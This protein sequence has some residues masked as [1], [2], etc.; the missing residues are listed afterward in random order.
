[1]GLLL[2][3]AAEKRD[4]VAKHGVV[5]AGVLH[6]C[7]EFTFYAGDGLE[8]ELAEVG[9]GG[10]GLVGDSFFGERGEDF[11]EDVVY[12]R[13]SV[14]FAGKGSELG[15][16]LLGFDELLFFAGV[17]DAEGRVAFL[18]GHAAGAAIGELAETLVAVW[19]VRV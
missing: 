12:V 7:V 16:E 2:A 6:G 5:G 1:M 13:D 8:K 3:E 4:V 14:E 9:E 11:A 10:G 15:G 19:V 17:E 18:A